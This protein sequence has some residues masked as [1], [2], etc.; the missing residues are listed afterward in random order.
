MRILFL[1]AALTIGGFILVTLVQ[2]ARATTVL[3]RLLTTSLAA[4]NSL[5][6]L[7][8]I[9][10]VFERPGYF[11][12]IGLAYALLAFLFPLAFAKF[13]ESEAETSASSASD[14][15]ARGANPASDARTSIPAPP[16]SIAHD[17]EAGP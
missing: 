5:V 3:D 13:L 6:L 4:A 12:D 7:I 16:G 9:G 2:I 17:P 15:E 11:G 10:M 14:A 8:L 1:V